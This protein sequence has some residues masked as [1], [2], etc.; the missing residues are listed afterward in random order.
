M[1]LELIQ[2]EQTVAGRK[3]EP[4]KL[5][6]EMYRLWIQKWLQPKCADQLKDG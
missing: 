1:Q 2:V 3:E 4:G 6:P 5:H